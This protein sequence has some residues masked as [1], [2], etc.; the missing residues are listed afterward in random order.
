MVSAWIC[1]RWERLSKERGKEGVITTFKTEKHQRYTIKLVVS[2]RW[3]QKEKCIERIRST[4]CTSGQLM[5]GSFLCSLFKFK[6]Q[7][8]DVVSSNTT[9]ALGNWASEDV[10]VFFLWCLSPSLLLYNIASLCAYSSA[11][12]KRPFCFLC[13]QFFKKER[14]KVESL[15]SLSR[16]IKVS[17]NGRIEGKSFQ[18]WERSFLLASSKWSTFCWLVFEIIFRCWIADSKFETETYLWTTPHLVARNVSDLGC[19]N[20]EA[21]RTLRLRG[22]V[23]PRVRASQA[24]HT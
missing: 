22:E 8:K 9:L 19:F 18:L 4:V 1:Y 15:F 23:W 16:E 6:H 2:W 3:G 13:I 14:S 5:V 10:W 17:T 11:L 7:S 24:T 21:Q 12:A 20:L